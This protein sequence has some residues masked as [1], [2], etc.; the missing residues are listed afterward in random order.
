LLVDRLTATTGSLADQNEVVLELALPAALASAGD[1]R[2]ALR[3]Y[4]AARQLPETVVADASLILSELVTNAVLHARTPLLVW[5]E[6]DA[7]DLTVAV[8]DGGSA[9]PHL[10]PLDSGDREGGRGVAVIADLGADWGVLTT[11]LGKIVW[12]AVTN[13][14]GRAAATP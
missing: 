12:V 13:N 3:R 14:E 1:A 7:P 9:L 4:C 2:S 8:Q 6:Y 5:A 10:I 11:P